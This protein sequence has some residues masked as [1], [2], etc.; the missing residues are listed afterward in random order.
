MK[1]SINKVTLKPGASDTIEVTELKGTLVATPASQSVTCV[2]SQDEG[3]SE[4]TITVTVESTATASTV[5]ITLTD[6]GSIEKT[7]TVTVKIVEH[8]LTS[9][10]IFDRQEEI[11]TSLNAVDNK[12]TAVLVE[13]SVNLAA[14]LSNVVVSLSTLKTAIESIKTYEKT[15]VDFKR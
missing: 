15:V 6:S 13:T 2:V 1:V 4:A 9:E 10:S 5:L 8:F 12:I 11:A 3:S 7:K 14:T